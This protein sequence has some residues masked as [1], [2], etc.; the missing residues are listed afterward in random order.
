MAGLVLVA[1]FAINFLGRGLVEMF[2][3]FVLP[4]GET[5][6]WERASVVSIYS[7]ATFV[8]G[9]SAPVAGRLFDRFGPRAVY[10]VGF[11]AMGLGM[12]A[13]S[14]ATELWQ[15]WVCLGLMTG[16]GAACLSH[17][18]NSA[19]L[20][21][22]YR[23]GLAQAMSLVYS[24]FGIGMLTLVP[25]AQYLVIEHGWRH[26]WL[27][28]GSVMLVLLALIQFLPWGR[29]RAGNPVFA[30]EREA[31]A[32]AA[33]EA[34]G[35]TLRRALGHPAF[36]G[37]FFVY[38]FTSS[39]MFS[40]VVQVVPFLVEA[41]FPPLQAASAWGLSGLLLPVGMIGAGWLD[42][43][44]GRRPTIVLSYGIS[45]LGIASL[46]L[47]ARWPDFWLLAIFVVCFGGTLGARGPLIGTL[48]IAF[49]RGPSTAT[50][51]G[52]ISI[53]A[54]FG[55]AFGAWIGGALHDWTGGYDAVVGFALVSVM[56]GTI[57]F[58][59]TS[60]LQPGAPP[61]VTRP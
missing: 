48:S 29:I 11:G 10:V 49:F 7:V 52:A 58:L 23:D 8:T 46:W 53:G 39:G 17:A 31:A 40:I 6:G 4:L 41:G 47:L 51:V 60:R 59:L 26:T 14:T 5:F 50:I 9:L 18:P 57:T 19:L 32:R 28:F 27:G 24:A 56:C 42:G 33:G 35:W 55:S 2:T 44:L 34:V 3:V 36:W 21:R 22:W 30:A 12:A 37:L 38:I 13:A 43:K 16:F 1:V 15:F 54:G 20:G 25:L 61:P 45:L